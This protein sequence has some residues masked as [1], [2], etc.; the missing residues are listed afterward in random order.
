MKNKIKGLLISQFFWPENFPINDL[1]KS[2]KNI[3]FTILTGKPNYPEGR[4]FKGYKKK[5]VIKKKFFNHLVYNLPI[6]TRKSG[7]SVE[8]FLNYMSFL[9]SS[10][11]YGRKYLKE[12]DV[13]VIFVYNTSPI[14]QIITGIYFKNFFNVKLVVW[15]Q[16]IWPESLSATNHIKENIFFNF[17]RK[18]CHSIYKSS[19]ILLLQ[20][21]SFFKYFNNYQI[22]V[23]KIYLPNSSSIENSKNINKFKLKN[24]FKFNYVYAGNIG[25]AQGF[26]NFEIFLQKLYKKNKKIKFHLIGTGSYKKKLILEIKR[27]NLKNVE[28]YPY[29][30]NRYLS[31]IFKQA[32]ALFLTLKNKYIFNLTVPSKLQNYL[33]VGKPILASANGETKNIINKANCGIVVN[34]GNINSLVNATLSLC[35]KKYLKKLEKNSKSY[36]LKNFKLN[37]IK[38]KFHN[39]LTSIIKKK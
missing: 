25:M 37:L 11:Y 20:S 39:I 21:K 32:D 17:F 38:V 23:K 36:Y 16:D 4:L 28:I 13:D 27:K 24:K 35:N 12:S 5:G 30:D 33:S 2:T 34:H 14:T 10:I 3:D 18:L 29:I 31:S 8:L 7:S 1:I 26:E 19:D 22:S 15:V 6:I 9:I